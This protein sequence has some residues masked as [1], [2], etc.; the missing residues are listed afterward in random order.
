MTN[1]TI[2]YTVINFESGE[3]ERVEKTFISADNTRA[4]VAMLNKCDDVQCVD[5]INGMTGEVLDEF[6]VSTS[7]SEPEIEPSK[8]WA[9]SPWD[10]KWSFQCYGISCRNC[11]YQSCCKDTDIVNY[12]KMMDLIQTYGD[13]HD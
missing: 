7:K 12:E 13:V 8:R 11:P 10:D 6:N 5:V 2:C 9:Q 1:F 3:Q 4:Y